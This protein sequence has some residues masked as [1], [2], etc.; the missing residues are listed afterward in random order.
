[1]LKKSI[2]KAQTI[3]LYTQKFAV[4]AYNAGKIFFFD[5]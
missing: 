2:Q 5:V 4:K 1:M 3:H